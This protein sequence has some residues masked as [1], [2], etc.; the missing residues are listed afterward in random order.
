MFC[1]SYCRHGGNCMLKRGH[2]GKHG[3]KYCKWTNATAISKKQADKIFAR[4]AKAKGIPS[5][6]T[7]FFKLM[8]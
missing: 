3:S 5:E 8:T 7:Q 2:K 4:K 6:V 1:D